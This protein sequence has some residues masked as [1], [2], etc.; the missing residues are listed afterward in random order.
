MGM[1]F[2]LSLAVAETNELIAKP[3][4]TRGFSSHLYMN[5]LRII[6][7]DRSIKNTDCSWYAA[8]TPQS[9]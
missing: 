5:Q 3:V 1:G 6:S 2:C 7:D 4:Y 8:F 9:L